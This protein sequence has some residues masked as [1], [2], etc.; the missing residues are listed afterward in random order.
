MY[1]PVHISQ[2]ARHIVTT[3]GSVVTTDGF[4]LVFCWLGGSIRKGL[5]LSGSLLLIGRID[6]HYGLITHC[7]N[8][9]NKKELGTRQ[10]N[11]LRFILFLRLL[12]QSFVFSY[13]DVGPTKWACCYIRVFPCIVPLP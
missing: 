13:G 1:S 7:L 12:Q 2:G 3:L 5:S 8:R 9:F 6:L 11:L 4:E 10:V